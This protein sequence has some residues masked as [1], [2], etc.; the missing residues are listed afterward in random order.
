MKTVI[1][2]VL[3]LLILALIYFLVQSIN[4]P[5]KF[6]NEKRL[7]ESV[8]VNKMKDI[9]KAQMAYRGITKEFAPN[10]DTLQHVLMNDSFEVKKV[11]GDPDDP[12]GEKVR[13][14]VSYV[15]ARDSVAN[16]GFNLDSLRFV[17][18]AENGKTFDMT[19]RVIEYQKTTVPVVQ[20]AARY[21]DFMGMYADAKYSKYDDGY[22]P[23]ELIKFGDLSKPSTSG[24][25]DN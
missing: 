25:W 17:P 14:E 23:N 21:S 11:F 19:S 1:N 8:V 2:I 16:M 22:N 5:I 18:Y 9:R 4:E 24:T 15:L 3:T 7:R 12:T 10:F 20:V 6:D 13:Y